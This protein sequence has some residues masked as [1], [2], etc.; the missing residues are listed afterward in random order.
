MDLA[1]GNTYILEKQY[2]G[3]VDMT[4]QASIDAVFGP[5]QPLPVTIYPGQRMLLSTRDS[6]KIPSGVIGKIGMRSSYGRMGFL[7]PATNADP[8]FEGQLTMS[9][10]NISNQPILIRPGDKIWTIHYVQ[11]M[12]RTEGFYDGRYQ[13]QTGIQ[14]PIA[15][16]IFTLDPHKD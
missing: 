2:V 7:S 9:L 10:K 12:E 13:G 8:G 14:P 16:P 15:V 11:L 5:E 3:H 4:N 1:I 6:Y